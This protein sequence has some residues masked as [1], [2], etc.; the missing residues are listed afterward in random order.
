[1]VWIGASSINVSVYGF[2]CYGEATLTAAVV[3][4]GCIA[5]NGPSIDR[6]N[7]F[8]GTAVRYEMFI[9]F[10]ELMPFT[11]QFIDDTIL[12]NNIR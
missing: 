2:R 11:L 12:D 6:F 4:G 8:S 10:R 9:Y 7:I 1:M 3:V 5:F